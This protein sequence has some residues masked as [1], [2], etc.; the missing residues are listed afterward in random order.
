LLLHLLGIV[1]LEALRDELLGVDSPLLHT[2]LKVLDCLRV[3]LLEALRD[4]ILEL[5]RVD[6]LLLQPVLKVLDDLRVNLLEA[7][8]DPFL[9]LLHVDT[10]LLQLALKILHELLYLLLHLLAR[11]L[12]TIRRLSGD[13]RGGQAERQ[14]DGCPQKH[15]M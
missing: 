13:L 2:V 5:L 11:V 4:P 10:L 15:L 9:E 6:S 3:H 1:L 14:R 8:R 12:G 7:L